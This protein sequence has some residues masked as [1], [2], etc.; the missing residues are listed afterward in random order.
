MPLF[1]CDRG[2]KQSAD[3][4]SPK[5]TKNLKVAGFEVTLS[6]RFCLTP[7]DPKGVFVPCSTLTSNESTCAVHVL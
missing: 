2:A 3:H 6:G 7:E 1:Y 5:V 4:G